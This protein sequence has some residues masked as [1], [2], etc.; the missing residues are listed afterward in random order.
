MI[1]SRSVLEL[2][3]VGRTFGNTRVLEN[4]SVR[5][6]PGAVSALV[7]ASGCGKSTLL[8][9]CNGLLRPDVGEVRV[10]GEP[11]D[12]GRLAALRRR[13]GYAVQGHGLFPH[14]RAGANISVGG[15]L[16]GWTRREID[17]RIDQLLELV[18]LDR[19]LLKRFPHELSGGQQQRVGLAR[20]LL[21][22]PELLLLDEPFAAIDPITRFEIH[23]Q[24]L[25]ALAEEPATVVL[26]THDL[27]EA[28]VLADRVLF[29]HAG[30]V[31]REQD[32]EELRS[33]H[34]GEEP[35]RVLRDIL[36]QAQ[37]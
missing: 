32:V 9:L 37:S 29:M 24:L 2:V 14:L 31:Y 5:F 30:A 28:M 13:I 18:Q 23:Q 35:E 10:F 15:E 21:L 4:T 8:K 17:T 26:V 19:E 16:A 11:I 12:Y 3:N 25:H 27:R 20:A 1:E 36:R 34:A 6:H 7:G 22:R 33:A